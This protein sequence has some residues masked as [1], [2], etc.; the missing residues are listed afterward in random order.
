M[1]QSDFSNLC[2][3][4]LFNNLGISQIYFLRRKRTINETSIISLLSRGMQLFR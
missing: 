2:Q 4:F 1:Q 3:E